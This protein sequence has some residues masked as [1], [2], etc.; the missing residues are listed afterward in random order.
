MSQVNTTLDALLAPVTEA[1]RVLAALAERDLCARMQGSYQGEHA[2]MKEALNA[3]A[4]ALHGALGQVA[5]SAA[6]VS[7][8][9][10]QIA[11]TSQVVADGA[12][13]QASALEETRGRLEEMRTTT[14]L[15]REST[16]QASALAAAA[17]GAA[18][19][20]ARSMGQLSAAMGQIRTSAEGTS[21]IIKDI[22][23]I[24]FQTNLLALN[25]A[26]EAARA[27]E[28]GRGF[29][30]VAE[31]VRSLALRSKE[32]AQ[33]TE[34]LIRESVRQTG[35]GDLISREVGSKLAEIVTSV[36][37]VSEIVVEISAASQEQ[38][39]GIEQVGRAMAEMDRVIQ[40]NAANSERSSSA[41]AELASQ[42]QGLEG[43]VGG[44]QLQR[45][46][47]AASRSAGRTPVARARQIRA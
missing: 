16:A 20:G 4:E 34:A 15:A 7:G 18:D 31:E 23:E 10:A 37:R 29:A 33:K 41:A 46:A 39:T 28:A 24:A 35:Q 9:A 3:T 43:L 21:A 19:Q 44:F 25:A 13:Q 30:V 36:S 40:Q 11:T 22:N 42:A 1:T 45:V 27:G 26:V 6:E 38:T 5:T 12:A 8:A 47:S 2:T 32:A 14:G 17:R